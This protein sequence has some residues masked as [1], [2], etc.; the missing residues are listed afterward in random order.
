VV[1]GQNAWLDIYGLVSLNKLRLFSPWLQ[2]TLGE[3]IVYE[4]LGIPRERV[5]RWHPLNRSLYYGIRIHLPGLLLNAKGDRIAMHSSVETRYPFL[6]E[7]VFDYLAPLHPRWKMRGLQEKYLLRRLAERWLPAE[8][9]RRRKAMFR[10]PFDSFFA[11]PDA[12]EADLPPFVDQ[13]LSEESLKRTGYFNPEAVH[14]WRGRFRQ[15]RAGSSPRISV[16]MGLVGVLATQLWHHLYLGGGLA[17]LPT[18]LP[19]RSAGDR[20]PKLRVVG[21]PGW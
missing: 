21:A 1:G 18:A 14:E 16:E 8:I 17:D 4:D 15:M 2:E 13:L 19:G 10:A 9:S 7:D 5:T 12:G 6:D 11:D 20:R 3:R